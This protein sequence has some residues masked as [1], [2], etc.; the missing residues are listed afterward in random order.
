MSGWL[1]PYSLAEIE[2]EYVQGFWLIQ[3]Y[4]EQKVCL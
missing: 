1:L 4:L 3:V 2:G